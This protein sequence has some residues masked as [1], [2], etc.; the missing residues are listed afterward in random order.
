M[1]IQLSTKGGDITSWRVS[2]DF[3]ATYR[4][5]LLELSVFRDN[6]AE[7]LFAHACATLDSA[8]DSHR[9]LVNTLN[10]LL[11]GADS[12]ATK[13]HE[14]SSTFRDNVYRHFDLFK[15]PLAFYQFSGH[16]LSRISTVVMA[17]TMDEMGSDADRL[18]A[19]AL[20]AVGTAGRGEYSPA[21]PLQM[22]LV[23][24]DADGEQRDQILRFCTTLHSAFERAGV[25]VDQQV[26]PR[27][28]QWRGTMSEWQRRC[29]E[30]THISSEL[31]LLADQYPLNETETLA[32]S[33]RE[34]SHSALRN[35]RQ[36]MAALVTRMTSLSNGIGFMG[37]LKLER[38]G[39][40]RGMFNLFEHG[41]FPFSGAVSTLALIKGSSASSSFER[42]HDLLRQRNL[43]VEMA[44]R[45]LATWH[46]LQS[47]QLQRES[48]SHS[49]EAANRL[50]L[51]DPTPLDADELQ[52][53]KKNLELVG[54]I[55]Y[56]VVNTFSETGNNAV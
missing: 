53:L 1:D 6:S 2:T 25:T 35:S 24:E 26:S 8:T 12:R 52:T 32:R 27:A 15:S 11:D 38:S 13:L 55:Q 9:N 40:G 29:R 18:P 28:L 34:M 37:R 22:I 44:E 20:I 49:G 7:A 50:L 36:T 10:S 56:H 21:A 51:L 30:N 39:A 43:D 23:H 41:L 5:A 54:S 42:I 45:M 31:Y 4:K 17:Q 19:M 14:I 33:F 16:Y 46:Y 48:S 3:A 47:Q